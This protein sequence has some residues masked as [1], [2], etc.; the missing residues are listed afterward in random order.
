M[1]LLLLLLLLT[2]PIRLELES[3]RPALLMAKLPA[4]TR[5]SALLA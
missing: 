2:D 4:L 1:W 5:K 3:I